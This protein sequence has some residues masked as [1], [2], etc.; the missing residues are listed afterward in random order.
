ML[1][2][3]LLLQIRGWQPF[4]SVGWSLC[5]GYCCRLYLEQNV[6]HGSGGRYQLCV[7]FAVLGLEE[8]RSGKSIL[9]TLAPKLGGILPQLSAPPLLTWT[10][11]SPIPPQPYSLCSQRLCPPHDPPFPQ[12][13]CTCVL[14]IAAV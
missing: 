13:H 6:G 8:E 2:L 11:P 5:P 1:L 3:Q 14:A 12:T 4:A 10:W 9:S 7:T